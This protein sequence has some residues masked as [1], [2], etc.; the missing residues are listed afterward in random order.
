MSYILDALKKSEQEK[1]QTDGSQTPLFLHNPPAPAASDTP[2]W[3]WGL[4]FGLLVA[5]LLFIWL[6]YQQ[7]SQSSLLLEPKDKTSSLNASASVEKAESQA[8][9]KTKAD[10][11]A[12]KKE[13][14]TTINAQ[15][16]PAQISPKPI[17]K[18]IV[19]AKPKPAPKPAAKPSTPKIPATPPEAEIETTA[20]PLKALKRIPRLEINSHIFSTLASK[21]K[22]TINSREYQEG[23]WITDEVQLHEITQH[24]VRLKLGRWFID[25]GRSKGWQPL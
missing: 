19:P 12:H 6:I 13:A 7:I 18:P 23:D 16:A 4:G 9:A 24:G 15:N 2:R 11:G 10:T 25:V 1:E 21:R 3:V 22:V 5:C 14:V 8:P 20:A 17:H